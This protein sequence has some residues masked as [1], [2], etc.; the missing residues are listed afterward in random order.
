MS[1]TYPL[2]TYI[3]RSTLVYFCYLYLQDVAVVCG[4]GTQ[5][6]GVNKALEENEI[7]SK[8]KKCVMGMFRSFLAVLLGPSLKIHSRFLIAAS[9]MLAEG[10][11]KEAIPSIFLPRKSDET[12]MKSRL[13]LAK[14]SN[15]S[16]CQCCRFS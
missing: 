7:R 6:D 4:I 9:L 14:I 2:C 15:Q 8:N 5:I 16:L 13:S 3:S 11:H 10:I 12:N 1:V